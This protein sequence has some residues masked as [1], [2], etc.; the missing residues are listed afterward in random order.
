MRLGEENQ[1]ANGGELQ[2]NLANRELRTKAGMR[3]EGL[4]ILKE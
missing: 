3:V 1:K 2:A 4:I